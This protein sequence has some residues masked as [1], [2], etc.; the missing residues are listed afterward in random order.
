M[1][2]ARSVMS[3]NWE[4]SLANIISRTNANLSTMNAKFGDNDFSSSNP[5]SSQGPLTGRTPSRFQAPP[6]QFS[7]TP[8]SYA[9]QNSAPAGRPPAGQAPGAED[10]EARI[11]QT[12]RTLISDKFVVVE[13]S[14]DSLRQQIS[15]LSADSS[16]VAG[17]V[18][19]MGRSVKA[20]ESMV[21][22]LRHDMN[23]RR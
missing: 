13:R 12:V 15:S 23:G 5:A 21:E 6:R 4:A 10:L 3:S 18:A 2:T 7:R 16:R 11:V 17:E 22:S 19:G 20:Q 1:N 9:D 8:Q 14:L